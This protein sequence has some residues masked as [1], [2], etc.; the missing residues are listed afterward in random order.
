MFIMRN[1]TEYILVG[2]RTKHSFLTLKANS[3]EQQH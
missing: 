1:P 2:Y 3:F